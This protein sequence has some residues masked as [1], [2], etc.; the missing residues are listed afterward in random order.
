MT[1]DVLEGSRRETYASQQALVAEHAERTQLPY[2]LPGALEAS[3]AIL[4]HYVRS[5]ERLDTNDPWTYIWCRELVANK[6][7]VAVGGFSSGGLFVHFCCA[8]IDGDSRGVVGF[9]KF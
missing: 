6:W 3:T 8:D 5:R 2:E 4:S 1:R 7:P 9:R